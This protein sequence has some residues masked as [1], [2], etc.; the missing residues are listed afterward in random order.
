MACTCSNTE[1]DLLGHYTLRD[2]GT[3]VHRAA[4]LTIWPNWAAPG[5][6][7]HLRFRG[8]VCPP[9]P[10][11]AVQPAARPRPVH[12]QRAA[13]QVARAARLER[14]AAARAAERRAAGQDA[15]P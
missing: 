5:Y 8:A 10:Q 9:A 11:P 2:D 4:V 13:H 3:C 1:R 14:D 7:I 15:T 6:N 12:R